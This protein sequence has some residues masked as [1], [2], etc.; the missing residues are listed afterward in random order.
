MAGDRGLEIRE[1]HTAQ[2]H[3]APVGRAFQPRPLVGP[4]E[5][6]AHPLG[7]HEFERLGGV[8]RRLQDERPAAGQRRA[9][10]H[11][12]ISGPEEAVGGPPA[13]MV[14]GA[15][16]VHAPEAPQLDAHR[17]MGTEDAL[18]LARGAR[19]EEQHR[20]I[21]WQHRRRQSPRSA[22]GVPH[23]RT[24]GTRPTLRYPATGSPSTASRRRNGYL[25]DSSA[26]GRAVPI[27]GSSSARTAAKSFD[28]TLR[29]NNNAETA[30]ARIR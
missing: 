9:E 6:K 11:R 25:A 18:G 28:S 27:S 4:G 30:E 26:P 3:P 17:A 19:R 7:L 16:T 8:K 13:N 2:I 15:E 23:D 12:E 21:A 10:H 29:S 24:P 14:V 20:G 5:R 1:P 22:R